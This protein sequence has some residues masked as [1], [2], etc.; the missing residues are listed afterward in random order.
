[1]RDAITGITGQASNQ[2]N[3]I[4]RIE[5]RAIE[6]GQHGEKGTK[7]SER[8]GVV[9]WLQSRPEEA[10]PLPD[11]LRTIYHHTTT[12]EASASKSSVGRASTHIIRASHDHEARPS[13]K[14]RGN[15]VDAKGTR[16][17]KRNV[18]SPGLAR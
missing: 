13:R 15:E 1:M 2:R 14:S 8:P 18:A 9:W 5:D 3:T 6:I 7:V 10:I 4:P 16:L 11:F 17:S 12:P